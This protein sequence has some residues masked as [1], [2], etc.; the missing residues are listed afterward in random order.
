MPVSE[1]EIRK[2]IVLELRKIPSGSMSISE[3]IGRLS[4]QMSLD[5]DDL[6]ILNDRNDTKFS[7]KVRNTVSHIKNATSLENQ[8]LAVYNKSSESWTLTPLGRSVL[9]SS[10][11]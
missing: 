10:V 4:G 5:A 2:N 7:Q 1:K 3:L 6:K 9:I 8:G 11:R